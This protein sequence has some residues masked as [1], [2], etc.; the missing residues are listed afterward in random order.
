MDTRYGYKSYKET[1]PTITCLN[2]KMLKYQLTHWMN[3]MKIHNLINFHQ[4]IFQKKKID[5][6]QAPVF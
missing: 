1:F 6:C 3:N 2:N 4:D 5:Q